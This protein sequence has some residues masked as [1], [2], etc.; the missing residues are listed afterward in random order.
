MS[1]RIDVE[2]LQARVQALAASKRLEEALDLVAG[3]LEHHGED[4]R[5]WVVYGMVLLA[6]D[7]QE[8]AEAAGRRALELEH[9]SLGALDLLIMCA[10][11][12]GQ[13][14]KALALAR[15]MVMAAPNL[16]K[17]HFWVGLL[18]VGNSTNR[19]ELDE[20]AAAMGRALEIDPEDPD[21]FRVAAL[22]A[23]LGG[24]TPKALE[25][26]RAGL[27]TAPNDHGLL[28]ASGVIDGADAVVGDRGTLLRGMLAVNPLDDTVQADFAQLFLE[29]LRPLGRLPWV[30]GM[31]GA[32]VVERGSGLPGILA[33]VLLL[34]LLAGAGWLRYRRAAKPLPA[35]YVEEI[36]NRFPSARTGLRLLAAAGATGL[37]G[38]VLGILAPD[39]RPGLL[40]VGGGAVLGFI[41]GTLLD[42]ASCAPPEAGA[43][44]TAL[45]AHWHRRIGALL[46]AHWARFRMGCLGILA[47]VLTLPGMGPAAGMIVLIGA[48][49]LLAVGAQLAILVLRLGPGENPWVKGRTLRSSAKRSGLAG[50]GGR[51]QSVFYIGYHLFLPLMFLSLGASMFAGG[52][53]PGDGTGTPATKDG[54]QPQI[55]SPYLRPT[56]I[57]APSITFE[58]PSFAPVEIPD[59]SKE[60]GS[61]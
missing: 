35:G 16:A 24:N 50:I 18:L 10:H 54:K 1:N 52:I 40:L 9:D 8:A 27:N 43:P 20:A 11:H 59:F 58:V 19:T 45:I 60:A 36:F 7:R 44:R 31:L 15:V 5:F 13:R 37:A 17:G 61:D 46:E 51:M 14:E 34:G 22:I 33:A 47:L 32:L 48:G 25:Y 12:A 29:R 53:G 6:N 39:Q 49:W 38:T 30:H 57:P 28:L 21:H 26:L 41:G 56:P 3:Q 42:K 55:D 23:D 4:P 2:L